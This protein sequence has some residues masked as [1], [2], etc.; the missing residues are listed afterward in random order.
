[1]ST[2]LPEVLTPGEVAALL[3]VSPKTVARWASS[4]ALPHFRTPGGHRRYRR[5]DV[6]AVQPPGSAAGMPHPDEIRAQAEAR[7]D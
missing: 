2:P 7:N 4:G 1:M 3:G 5:V 6:L